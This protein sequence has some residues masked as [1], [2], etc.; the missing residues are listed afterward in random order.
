M[1]SSSDRPL[2]GWPRPFD[3]GVDHH[4]HELLE[5]YGRLPSQPCLRLAVVAHEHADFGGAECGDVQRRSWARSPRR[6]GMSRTP[7][8]TA[9]IYQRVL[10]KA[11]LLHLA[12]RLGLGLAFLTRARNRSNISGVP[13]SRAPS[14]RR[15]RRSASRRRSA[16]SFW[17]SR[18]SCRTYSLGVLNLPSLV[19]S[20]MKSRSSSGMV[21]LSEA[22]LLCLRSLTNIVNF[23]HPAYA[24]ERL[25]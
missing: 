10:R 12:L 20:S 24:V 22:T 15:C 7:S 4:R 14:S 5:P 23:C 18:T 11:K 3:I 25:A 21:T 17:S 8:T 9:K 19:R 16:S 6:Q 13:S 2:P 1:R